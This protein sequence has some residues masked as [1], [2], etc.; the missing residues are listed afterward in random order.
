MKSVFVLFFAILIATGP[1]LSAQASSQVAAE[2]EAI[3][4]VIETAY[5]Q[6]IYNER[7]AE[8]IMSGIHSEF[9]MLYLEDNTL[10]KLPIQQWVEGIERSKQDH[11]EPPAVLFTHEST[12]LQVVGNTAVTQVDVY[13]GDRHLYTDFMS[14]YKFADGWKI[15]A[16]IYYAH[17]G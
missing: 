2:R 9:N 6:G 3:E 13:Q 12:V 16:K 10:G 5:I 17:P 7:D 14:M 1:T 8:K 4:A 11:P 15:V